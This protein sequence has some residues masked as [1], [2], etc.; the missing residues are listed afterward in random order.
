VSLENEEAQMDSLLV[1]DDE[2]SRLLGISRSKFH[3]LVAQGLIPRL[4]IGRSARYRRTDL[5]TFTEHLAAEGGARS[6]A[7][8]ADRSVPY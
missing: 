5:S 6:E 8:V 3:V 2:A 7:P 1:K 4:K